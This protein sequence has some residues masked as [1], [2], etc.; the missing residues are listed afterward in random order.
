MKSFLLAGVFL[1]VSVSSH[2]G[3]SGHCVMN[4]IDIHAVPAAEILWQSF[5]V[6]NVDEK[7]FSFPIPTVLGGKNLGVFYLRKNGSTPGCYAAQVAISPIASA[8]PTQ[9]TFGSAT[10]VCAE[11]FP[12]FLIA[13][14]T[15]ELTISVSC[16]HETLAH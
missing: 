4:V 1:F 5:E 11:A 13:A 15:K 9:A 12:L 14:Y 8:I 10:M 6:Q 16:N 2:A 3:L 7:T